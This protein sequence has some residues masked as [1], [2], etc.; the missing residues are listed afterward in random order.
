MDAE[1]AF[2]VVHERVDEPP[3]LMEEGFAESVQEGAGFGET[4][5]V[6]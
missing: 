3:E 5:T 4:V 2:A 1:M 6:V